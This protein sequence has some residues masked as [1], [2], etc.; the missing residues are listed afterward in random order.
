MC[1]LLSKLNFTKVSKLNIL[2]TKSDQSSENY[3]QK[4]LIKNLPQ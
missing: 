2:I 4:F 1:Q 3:L